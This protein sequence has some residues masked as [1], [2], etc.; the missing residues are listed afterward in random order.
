[1]AG[2]K[3]ASIITRLLNTQ[4]TMIIHLEQPD[5][6]N[7]IRK[8]NLVAFE[9][10]T[11]ARLVDTLR[12]TGIELIS[13]VA[14]ENNEVI[15]HILFS[16]VTINN[17]SRIKIIGLAPMAVLPNWQNKGVGTQLVN[18]GLKACTNAGYDAV[19]VLGHAD[20]Y[21]CF[22]FSPAVNFGIKSE[23]NVPAEVFLVKESK[24]DILKHSKGVIKYHQ[25]FNEV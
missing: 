17:E 8:V 9:T 22:G 21:P 7:K 3:R 19:V 12:N 18:E 5:D 10:D 14:E 20:Y 1:L 2:D 16:P 23:Y 24:K 13:L 15:G 11:E 25:A 6:I 4:S